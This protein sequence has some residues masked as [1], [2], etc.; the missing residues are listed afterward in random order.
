M[1]N[2]NPVATPQVMP[3]SGREDVLPYILRDLTDRAEMGKAKY[4][5]YLQTHNGRSA[6]LDLYQ[7]LLD[8]TMYI[9]Q[10][11]IERDDLYKWSY[12]AG[13]LDGEGCISV[14]ASKQGWIHRAIEVC[15]TDRAP[16]DWAVKAT[17]YGVVYERKDKRANRRN[18]YQWVVSNGDHISE[19]IQAV[20]PYLKVKTPE[21]I[22]FLVADSIRRCKVNGKYG[23]V[24]QFPEIELQTVEI[25]RKLKARK[26]PYQE[27]LDLA[28]HLRQALLEIDERTNP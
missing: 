27:A 7:E 18:V 23:L 25:M 12:L 9:R 15:M 24:R 16:L 13:L 5:T 28:T 8:A 14:R 3:Q 11:I 19:I 22:L 10:E 1:P 26:I 20:L 21:A 17:G 6:L 2:V 4:G